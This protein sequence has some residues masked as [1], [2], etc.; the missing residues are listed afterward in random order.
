MTDIITASVKAL[1]ARLDS[2]LTT[3]VVSNVTE[4]SVFPYSVIEGFASNRAALKGGVMWDMTWT[5]H[6]F[7]AVAGMSEIA[8]IMGQIFDAVEDYAFDLTDDGYCCDMARAEAQEL[9][10]E[11]YDNGVPIRHG[12]TKIHLIATRL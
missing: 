7:S 11:D 8:T 3:P 5:V 6:S 9:Y 1:Y 12:E 4:G 10:I 2:E